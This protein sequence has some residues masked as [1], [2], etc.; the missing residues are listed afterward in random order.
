MTTYVTPFKEVSVKLDDGDTLCLQLAVYHH[1]DEDQEMLF[2][3]I[4]KDK[5]GKLKAQRGQAGIPKLNLIIKLAE[6][7]K[8]IYANEMNIMDK[9]IN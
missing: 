8:K 6:D 5:N 7:M 2:R 4:R 3:F 9:M 1:S